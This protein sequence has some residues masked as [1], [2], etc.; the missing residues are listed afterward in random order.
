MIGDKKMKSTLTFSLPEDQKEF[1]LATNGSKWANLVYVI[2]QEI[3]T[4]LKYDETLS[5][6]C[7]NELEK[8]RK[9]IYEMMKENRLNFD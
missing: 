1:E 9:L 8:L 2:D 4:R 3:R 7:R 5:D 6:S